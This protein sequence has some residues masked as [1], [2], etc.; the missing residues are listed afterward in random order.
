MILSFPTSIPTTTIGIRDPQ[1]GNVERVD[2]HA[3]LRRTRSGEPR[4]V[5]EWHD[6]DVQSFSFT[7]LN[8][9]ERDNLEAF[10]VTSAGDE[11]ALSWD[12]QVWYGFIISPQSEIITI[13]DNCSY[14]AA[15]EFLGRRIS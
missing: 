11:L 2:T 13:R 9:T 5:D 4:A 10:L 14:S 8:R 7:T 1:L 3:I 15:F 6:D 12:S